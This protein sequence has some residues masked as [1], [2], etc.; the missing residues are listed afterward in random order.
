[1]TFPK[2]F[3]TDYVKLWQITQ[4][5]VKLTSF[6]SRCAEGRIWLGIAGTSFIIELNCLIGH[7]LSSTTDTFFVEKQKI[8]QSLVLIG[9]G[10]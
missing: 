4:L 5:K 10:I 9:A 8:G 1:M 7:G 3:F 2:I 6:S